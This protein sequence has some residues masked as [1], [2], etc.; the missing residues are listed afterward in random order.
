MRDY[1]LLTS[2]YK[3]VW[4]LKHDILQGFSCYLKLH[5]IFARFRQSQFQVKFQQFLL[6]IF[7]H[8]VLFCVSTVIRKATDV[9]YY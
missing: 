1:E 3:K 7:N 4:L 2:K 6:P 8:N 9:D 5:V